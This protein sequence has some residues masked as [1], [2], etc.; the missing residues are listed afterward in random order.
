MLFNQD[1]KM[2]GKKILFVSFFLLGL[3]LMASVSASDINDMAI[4]TNNNASE[5]L[6]I[7]DEID[8]QQIADGSDEI[9][10]SP[11]TNQPAVD[12]SDNED[13]LSSASFVG[14]QD[15]IDDATEGSEISLSQDYSLA[16]GGN[17]L[18]I[19]KSIT[20]NGN[21]HT[22]DGD[23][24]KTILSIGADGKNVIL[25]NIKFTNG[26][27][28]GNGGAILNTYSSTT[29]TLFNCQFN[30]NTAH[31]NGGAIY[32]KGKLEINESSFDSNEAKDTSG[33]AIYSKGSSYI[34]DCS[35]DDNY[36]DSYGGAIYS[37]AEITVRDCSFDNNKADISGGAIYGDGKTN[38]INSQFKSNK[39]DSSTTKKTLGGA[40]RSV[41]ECNIYL[42]YFAKNYAGS[43]GGA[44]YADNALKVNDSRFLSN[45]VG[46][47][48]GQSGAIECNGTT[49]I[50]DSEISKNSGYNA[51]HSRG[52]CYLDS[53]TFS[54]NEA[55]PVVADSDLK[56]TGKTKFNDNKNDAAGG[57]A[58]Y[59]AKDLYIN[60]NDDE[61]ALCEF[62]SNTGSEG[63]LGGA[64]YCE[65]NIYARSVICNQNHVPYSPHVRGGAVYCKG[66]THFN[67]SEFTN[68][69]VVIPSTLTEYLQTEG[70]AIWSNGKCYIDSCIFNDNQAGVGGAIC[71]YDDLKITGQNSFKNN[72]VINNPIS[73]TWDPDGG[74]IYCKGDASIS[75]A[76]FTLNIATVDGGAIF[77][78]G[79]CTVSDSR[80]INNSADDAYAFV[81]YSE[82]SYGGAIRSKESIAV[83]N[84]LFED[85]Y[86][87]T[88]GGAIYADADITVKGS[89]FLHNRVPVD[90]GAIFSKGKTSLSDSTFNENYAS[91]VNY[92]IVEDSYGGAVRSKGLITVNNC[93]FESN[94]AD[95]YGGAI[96]ADGDIKIKDSSFVDH[97]ADK[98][99][100]AVYCKGD[101][102]IDNTIFSNNRVDELDGGAI[103]CNGKITISNSKFKDNEANG[104]GAAKSYGGA[105]RANGFATVK[106]STFDDNF[107]YN[108]GG[109]IYV[110]AGID[111][112][113]CQFSGN[114]VN[115]DGGAVYAEGETYIYN[116]KFE[117]NKATGKTDAR[118]FG[119]A[120][121]SNGDT[122]VETSIFTDN[123]AYN[124]GG[125]LY[126]NKETTIKKSTFTD[127]EAND[128]GGAVYSED[129]ATVTDSMFNGNSVEGNTARRAFGGGI[130]SYGN[131]ILKNTNFYDNYADN[132]GGAVFAF[133][134]IKIKDCTF[135]K[136]YAQYY[137]GAVYTRTINTIV[138]NSVFN[139]NHAMEDDGGAIY[140]NN[141]CDPE[142]SSCS[143][144]S[145]EAKDRGGA[146]YVDSKNAPLKLS[147]CT[148]ISNEAGEGGAVYT[149][150]MAGRT[151]YSL[152]FKNKATSGDGGAI[153]INNNCDP[154]FYSCRF[155]NNKCDDR[156]GAL[157]L[158]SSHADLYL[159]YCTFVD[160]KAGNKGHSVFNSGFYKEI[161]ECWLGE[162]NPSLKNQFKEW[163]AW[164]AADT[165]FTDFTPAYIS[166]GLSNPLN[167]YI[168]NSYNVAVRFR[169][170]EYRYYD[171]LH[172]SAKFFGDNVKFSNESVDMNDMTAEVIFT[173]KNPT[174]KLQL[175]HQVVSL[176]PRVREKNPSKVTITSCENIT[177]PNELKVDYEI[178]NMT[179]NATYVIIDENSGSGDVV[180]EGKITSP[181]STLTIENL[182]PGKYYIR[183]DNNQNYTTSASR[184]IARFTV[185]RLVSA[186]VTADNVTYGN[187]TTIT[188]RADYDGIYNVSVNGRHIEMEVVN[189]ISTR[190]V[191]F[192][193]G[194]YQT[195]TSYIGNNTKFNCN[196]ASFA[197]FKANNNVVVSVENVSYGT[198]SIIKINADADGIYAV[199]VNG[200]EYNVTV[201]HGVGS[202]SV[203]L[204]A[205]GYYANVSFDNR[206]YITTAKNATFTVYKVDVDLVIVVF[207]EVY[208]DEIEGIVYADKDGDYNL[209]IAGYTTIIT[210]KDSFAYFEHTTLDAGSYQASVSFA[211]DNNYNSAFNITIFTVYPAG[212]SFELVINSSEIFYGG[213]AT[214]SPKLP[215][216]AT[217]NISYYLSN[218][219]FLGLLDV[220]ENLTLHDF[221]AG[222]YVIIGNYSGDHNFIPATDSTFL[223]VKPAPNNVVVTASNVTYGNE[224][225][226]E[227]SA[228]VDGTY[229][230]D[231]NGTV[232]NLTVENGYA[233]K[234]VRLNAGAYHAN[235]SF[236][237]GNY[238]TTAKNA[239]FEVYKADVDL[240]IAASNIVYL[241]ELKGVIYSNLDGD[242]NLTIGD[243]STIIHVNDGHGEF[244]LGILDAG[245]YDLIANYSGDANH[246][247]ASYKLP[248]TVSLAPNNALVTVDNVTYGELATFVVS[249]DA[250]GIY[251]LD[252][253]GTIYNATVTNGA[254][255]I[256]IALDAGIYYANVTFDNKNYN[257]SSI[258][259]SFEVYKANVDLFVSAVDTVYPEDIEGII[260]SDVDGE[261]DLTIGE[262]STK[263]DI[264][265]SFAIF[266]AGG[267]DAGNYTVTLSYPGDRNHNSGSYSRNVT[268]EKFS[269][270]LKLDVSNINY[271]DVEKIGI[272]CD[273]PGSV[274][275]TV[276]G[277]TETLE[278]NGQNRK[279]LLATIANVLR[280]SNTASLSLYGLN[281]G[282]YPVTVTYNGDK[283]HESVSVSA[284][285]K[286]NPLNVTMDVDTD[287]IN[288]GDDEKITISLSLNV[289]GNVTVTVD[290][291]K[292]TA[293]VKDG[294]AALSIPN[295][296]AGNKKAEVYYSGDENHNPAR[297]T[298]SFSVSKLKP[299]M[300]AQSNEPFSGE[301]LHIVVKLPDDATG[302]V[303]MPV[304]GKNYTSP[305]KNGK[306]VFDIPG[307]EAGKYLLTAYYSGDDKYE[308]D[309][310]DISVTVRAKGNSHNQSDVSP[311][312]DIGSKVTG[313]PILA[314]LLTL[315]AVGL[316]SAR[317]SK[318]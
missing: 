18:K 279:I 302:T 103:Y 230:L 197:V 157:Y 298:V 69:W 161:V 58:M 260:Y 75:G 199:D 277:I 239:T 125:A 205:G 92:V 159:G 306:A 224:T 45:S 258:N 90:G 142:F 54:Y 290:G 61:D 309:Q 190:Q 233:S 207:D 121:R 26:K 150:T 259:A 294:K 91:H 202:K 209:T 20:I 124:N 72:T 74:A 287:D 67:N 33:G 154:K 86:A 78:E 52:K 262:W 73:I 237:D 278:L 307:L 314:L 104:Y 153:Y 79:K 63:C 21:N 107:A 226:I 166:I 120:V 172:S 162:N 222:T 138:S 126:S 22:L 148:F 206:N 70:G 291:K 27:S 140:I 268:V 119:G 44:V 19:S 318:K 3:L 133:K 37:D 40:I 31:D 1:G 257:T 47:T 263:I 232:Y 227:V 96:Y 53:C 160:N 127:N 35:F 80:F 312:I 188:L 149:G 180:R 304:G 235:A 179:G 255:N 60:W 213:N 57:G 16:D 248:V 118:S 184:A 139:D 317:K 11:D 177:Y 170:A 4:G 186:N 316:S 68:N 97:Y 270:E 296:S 242:Y 128:D 267:F 274:N 303:T 7:S 301:V 311:G 168:G 249:A 110:N 273:I 195:Q 29:L 111:I 131:V 217:G 215:D 25:K 194:Q 251:Q 286:V 238:N 231:L 295:L 163:H 254:G 55:C 59:A 100:G 214:V 108:L 85:N 220:S 297:S 51:L 94:G 39:A 152:F 269:P 106:N 93:S 129:D 101:A 145:N 2:F 143:F 240:S 264:M 113:D 122:T 82:Y 109:V 12:S 256:S 130:C 275:I 299:D 38:V 43:S 284:E 200:T 292:Y 89:S 305:V 178:I 247:N 141:S 285:F 201:S 34:M 250:D 132:R 99:G 204:N 30:D 219:T 310:I 146:I 271:G 123:Y 36:A 245:S 192:D 83:S 169:D 48:S 71:V 183:I 32:T 13:A 137:G 288:V 173:D 208:G 266:D 41:G 228:D 234:T 62:Y 95:D 24:Q 167:P 112:I 56:I 88:N 221:D 252:V 116:S 23:N 134:E 281:S 147:S 187:P 175:D 246:N 87:Y 218:G 196:E 164:P 211:G 102:I 280:S 8:H 156:G 300:S 117:E 216:T 158:D 65:G 14:L 181:K 6:T 49:T 276:N 15:N 46:G 243:N 315:I 308:A 244:N 189:G 198:P 77:C 81:P 66:E 253:N 212:T 5:E 293:Q 136:N 105:I 165:D 171:L 210:V 115:V 174:I 98:D 236:N 229:Q 241:E 203:R 10:A 76:N 282:S 151:T 114:K 265:D 313:N 261:Y 272:T 17:T 64:I 144:D 283:N 42:G 84:C 225:L 50:I 9:I 28:S 223:T 182:N 191:S 289:T 185:Y 193:V 135:I 155:E 176:S